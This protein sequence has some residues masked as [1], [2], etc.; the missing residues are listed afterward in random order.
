MSE[1][2]KKQVPSVRFKGFSGEWEEKKLGEILKVNSGRDYKH[3][4]SGDIPVYGTGGYMTSV[5]E[6]LYDQDA[7]GIGRKGTIDK[8][9]Y[10]KGPFWTVD[11]LFFITSNISHI[12]FIY[13]LF[14]NISWKKLDES[15]GVPSLSK[16]NIESV[17]KSIPQLPEQQKICRFFKQLDELIDKQARKVEWTKQLKKGFLQKMFPKNGATQP[18]VRFKGFSGDWEEKKLGEGMEEYTDR[19]FIEDNKIYNQISIKNIGEIILRGEKNGEKIGR[20]RQAKINLKDYP[21]TLIF[22]RQTIEQGGIGFA[23]TYTDGAIVTENMPTISVDTSVFDKY[24]LICFFKTI[25]FRKHV[26]LPNI[27]GGTAQIA[28]HEDKVLESTVLLPSL[29][30]QQ[31][32]GTFFKNLD[33]LIEKQEKQL[34]L[35]KETKKGFLQ[36]MFV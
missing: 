30:E 23:P 7:V 36:K 31:K 27:E 20:K 28:I 4:S 22:T 34:A 6:Y 17:K 24:Y 13:N 12:D 15:T 32:I 2:K 35:L 8:P 10:L 1:E 11:T 26:I 33:T 19:V 25:L 16:L 18:E 9:L 21:T 3:L 14:Q 29:P 5:N